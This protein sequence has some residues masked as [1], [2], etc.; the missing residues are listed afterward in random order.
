MI[1]LQL[2]LEIV[3][4]WV[5]ETR[6]CHCPL[7]LIMSGQIIVQVLSLGINI[8][9][10]SVMDIETSSLKLVSPKYEGMEANLL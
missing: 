7:D 3:V 2:S 8:T 1:G 6:S 4:F 5:F 10:I 9:L